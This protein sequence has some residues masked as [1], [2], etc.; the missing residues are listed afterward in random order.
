MV[1]VEPALVHLFLDSPLYI[2]K[3]KAHAPDAAMDLMA[4]EPVAVEV[5]EMPVRPAKPRLHPLPEMPGGALFLIDRPGHDNT[6]QHAALEMIHKIGAA[7]KFL[8][9]QIWIEAADLSGYELTPTA[10]VSTGARVVLIMGLPQPVKELLGIPIDFM[11]TRQGALIQISTP[12]PEQ[13]VPDRNG[14]N[15]LWQALKAELGL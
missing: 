10:L 11:P 9:E 5:V 12:A 1:E 4:S 8:P 15:A 7:M 6:V 14:R 13:L 2:V 3:E